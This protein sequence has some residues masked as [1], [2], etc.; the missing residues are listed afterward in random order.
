MRI[1]SAGS[2]PLQ[3]ESMMN[4]L[5]RPHSDEGTLSVRIPDSNRV[6]TC[7]HVGCACQ[8]C[9]SGAETMPHDCNYGDE[10]LTR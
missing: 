4:D 9:A 7:S 8:L 1:P 10:R 3:P 6:A 2:I 5:R